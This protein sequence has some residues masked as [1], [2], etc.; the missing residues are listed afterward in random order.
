LRIIGARVQRNIVAGSLMIAQA[1]IAATQCR[2][3]V[4]N[5][6][7]MKAAKLISRQMQTILL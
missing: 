7:S 6:S 4:R 3:F 1:V 2:G 5:V